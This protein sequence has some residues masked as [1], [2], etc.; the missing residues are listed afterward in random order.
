MQYLRFLI[1][2][3]NLMVLKER[4]QLNQNFY[5]VGLG[6]FL[7]KAF[8]VFFSEFHNTTLYSLFLPCVNQIP[9]EPFCADMGGCEKVKTDQ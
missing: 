4:N 8:L 5:C 3:L 1:E 6:L 9:F 7:G 2:V